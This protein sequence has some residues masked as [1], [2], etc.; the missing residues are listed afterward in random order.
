MENTI[1]RLVQESLVVSMWVSAPA[2]LAAVGVGLAV[3]V[4]QTATQVQEQT[5]AYMP[6]LVAV[7]V[8][9]LIA[10]GW[11]L[12]QLVRLAASLFELIPEAGEW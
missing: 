2:A 10:G 11:M 3:A 4:L 5:L 9:L 1:I 8:V 12:A 7:G 6:K